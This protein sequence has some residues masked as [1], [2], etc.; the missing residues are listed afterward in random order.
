MR[1]ELLAK[2]EQEAA[3]LDSCSGDI[4][5][6]LRE[7]KADIEYL[8]STAASHFQQAMLNGEKSNAYR[9][10]LVA[11]ARLSPEEDSLEGFNEWGEADCFNKALAMAREVLGA[12]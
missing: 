11:I 9:R 12:A 2:M 8:A 3:A 7:A 6:L 5:A 10:A 1:S 4:A